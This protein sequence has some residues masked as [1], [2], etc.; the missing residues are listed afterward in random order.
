MK[1]VVFFDGDGTL[2]YPE[3]T[4]RTVAPHWIYEHDDPWSHL[5]PTPRTAET[6]QRLGEINVRRVL[7]ST[8]PLPEE[9][10]LASRRRA[11]RQVGIEHLLDDIQVAPVYPAGKG[12][13]IVALLQRYDLLAV[14]ALMV[15]DTLAWDYMSA[16]NVGVDAL[17]IA[18]SYQDEQARSLPEERVIAGLWDILPKL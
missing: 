12:E 10:A 11:A 6:L 14:D 7:L 5:V 3:S 1:K 4:K 16:Q 8:C 18:S 17:H 9:E 13:R 15:G 2:W